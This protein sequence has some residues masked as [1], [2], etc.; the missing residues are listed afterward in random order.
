MEP[1]TLSFPPR[2]SLIRICSIIP[3]AKPLGVRFHQIGKNDIG[4]S[5]GGN[6]V[7]L[8]ALGGLAEEPNDANATEYRALCGLIHRIVP[9]FR[10]CDAM[11]YGNFHGA[12]DVWVPLNAEYDKHRSEIETF[13]ANGAEIWHYCQ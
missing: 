11:S 1:N 2:S 9:E 5:G 13:R 4:L 12:L 10:L 7:L 3:R 8:P 6:E